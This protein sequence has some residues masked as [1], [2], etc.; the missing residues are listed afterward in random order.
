M[1]TFRKLVPGCVVNTTAEDPT[2]NEWRW[3]PSRENWYAER[4]ELLR[5]QFRYDLGITSYVEEPDFD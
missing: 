3:D 1:E 2:Q 4:Y 5:R